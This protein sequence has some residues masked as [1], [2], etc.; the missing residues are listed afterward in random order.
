MCDCITKEIFRTTGSGV[1]FFVSSVVHPNPDGSASF[2]RIR[3]SIHFP[4]SLKLDYI[5]FSSNLV[6]KMLKIMT[7]TATTLMREIKLAVGGNISKNFI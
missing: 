3:I 7:P 2:C 4:P 6:S 5:I 1:P